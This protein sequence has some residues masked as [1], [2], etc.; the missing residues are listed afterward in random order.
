MSVPTLSFD[1]WYGTFIT[2]EVVGSDIPPA[3][4][5]EAPDTTAPL[6]IEIYNFPICNIQATS[7]SD[8]GSLFSLYVLIS[9]SDMQLCS[10]FFPSTMADVTSKV[11][12][13]DYVYND[14]STFSWFDLGNDLHSEE[15]SS[16][17]QLISSRLFFLS[18]IHASHLDTHAM[19]AHDVQSR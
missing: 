8:L 5:V 15:G 18:S 19:V 16:S 7:L 9:G 2:R 11:P 4:S 3:V 17:P 13:L 14:E 6:E 12:E 1:E 10:T